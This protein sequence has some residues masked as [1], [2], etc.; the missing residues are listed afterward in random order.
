MVGFHPW[1]TMQI[2]LLVRV[3]S[4][5]RLVRGMIWNWNWNLYRNWNFCCVWLPNEL[6][7]ITPAPTTT[8]SGRSGSIRNGTG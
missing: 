8:S 6:E 2:C 3:P 4:R 1:I 5:G 7:S